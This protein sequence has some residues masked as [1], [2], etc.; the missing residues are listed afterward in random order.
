MREYKITKSDLWYIIYR[1]KEEWKLIHVEYLNWHNHWTWNKTSA[2]TF[3][4]KDDAVSALVI[5]RNKW[6][7]EQ[8]KSEQKFEKQSWSDF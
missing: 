4:N 5:M 1:R 7:K 2:K 3:Y 8:E 6:Q